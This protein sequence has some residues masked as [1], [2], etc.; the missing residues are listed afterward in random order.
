MAAEPIS[1]E[2][3]NVEIKKQDWF[4]NAKKEIENIHFSKPHLQIYLWMEHTSIIGLF[5]L[6]VQLT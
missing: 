3:K 1:S 5:L 6:A 2:K 4:Y